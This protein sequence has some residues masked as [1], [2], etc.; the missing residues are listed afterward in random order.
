MYVCSNL[1]HV[2]VNQPAREAL[3]RRSRRK[4]LSILC[5]EKFP[6]YEPYRLDRPKNRDPIGSCSC[7][8]QGSLLLLRFVEPR[9]V[10]YGRYQTKLSCMPC[11]R[12]SFFSIPSCERHHHNHHLH[13]HLHLGLSL[14]VLSLNTSAI[15]GPRS[16]V[17]RLIRPY[18]STLCLVLHR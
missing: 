8:S 9:Q 3:S 10:D 15:H 5:A 4:V 12:S 11:R 13:L 1:T 2:N 7:S 18:R 17:C 6:H 16:A 14:F